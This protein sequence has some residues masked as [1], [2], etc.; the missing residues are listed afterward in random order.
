M[1]V[2]HLVKFATKKKIDISSVYFPNRMES[3]LASLIY[4]LMPNAS[5]KITQTAGFQPTQITMK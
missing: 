2:A 1:K 4:N 5:Q 3:E